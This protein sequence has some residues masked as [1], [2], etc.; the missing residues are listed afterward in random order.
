MK[1]IYLCHPIGL[2]QSRFKEVEF[3]SRVVQRKLEEHNF[4]V[5]NPW[6]NGVPMS[7]PCCEH[8]QKDFSMLL[9]CDAIFLC[10]GWEYSSGCRAEFEVAVAC[11]KELYYEH[12]K[13]LL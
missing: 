2:D 11:R 3:R 13:T 4:E 9:A 10:D 8:M 5:V 12:V 6:D 1:R 7:A